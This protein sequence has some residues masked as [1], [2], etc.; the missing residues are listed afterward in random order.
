MSMKKTSHYNTQFE[1]WKRL[2]PK[3]LCVLEEYLD[4]VEYFQV[5]KNS[6]Y[7]YLES[8]VRV[9]IFLGL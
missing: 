1:T 5:S 3:L 9:R 7:C 8:D 4:K 6:I 2:G